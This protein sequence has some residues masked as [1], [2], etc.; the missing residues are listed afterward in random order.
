MK[1][2]L[3]GARRRSRPARA[4]DHAVRPPRRARRAL[5]D[6]QARRRVRHPRRAAGPGRRRRRPLVYLLQRSHDTTIE[7]DV[8]LAREESSE[9]PV[10]YVQYAHARI[11][12]MLAKAGGGARCGGARRGRRR[13][14]GGCTRRARADQA[15][16]L[17]SPARSR[18]RPSG[19]A[20]HRIA[21]YALELAQ[22]LHGFY[23]DCRVVGRRARGRRVLP[24]RP[25]GRGAAHDRTL[26]GHCSASALRSR[27]SDPRL[28]ALVERLRTES[29][30]LWP[31]PGKIARSAPVRSA[32][33]AQ[34]AS[35]AAPPRRAAPLGG[36]SSQVPDATRIGNPPRPAPPA[37][38]PPPRA[39]RAVI[40]ARIECSSSGESIPGSGRSRP[41]ASQKSA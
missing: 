27:C 12:S 34:M 41:K 9:N 23:R 39:A 10:Y 7:L 6:V 26:A 36:V 19:R 5:L 24:H 25:V 21:T 17:R 1:I 31:A 35:I 33:T 38:S 20:P 18:W 29:C 32:S 30:G 8:D 14:R 11:A 15:G 37:G 22:E 40:E 2:V 28:Q 4:R 13:R 16:C 3:P